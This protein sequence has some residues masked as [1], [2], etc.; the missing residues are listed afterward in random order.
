MRGLFDLTG[1]VVLATGA[2]SGIGLGFLQG[3]AKQ[4]A[5]VVVW[6]RRMDKN[7]EAVEALRA[8]GAP[9]VHAESVNVANDA[10]VIAAFAS[11]LKVMG[12]VDG[13]F[14][15]AGFHHHAESFSDM[16]SEMYHELL[17]VNLHGALYTLREATR[18]MRERARGGSDQRAVRCDH[19]AEAT[20]LRVRHRRAGGVPRVGRFEV[21]H[22]RHLG[23]RWWSVGQ[24]LVMEVFGG[25]RRLSRSALR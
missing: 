10:A 25:F 15:N 6:S 19:A 21:P 3:C 7:G 14:A 11:T 13:V 1:K 5:D 20:R 9:R 8:L 4:G 17:D 23:G 12:R 2:N 22:R 16:S 24:S 18:H